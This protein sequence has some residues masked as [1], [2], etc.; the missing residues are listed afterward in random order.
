[1]KEFILSDESVNSNNMIV[2]TDGI[3][4][5]RFLK[6]PVM[7]YNHDRGKGV[8]GRWENIRKEGGKLYG[9]PVFDCHHE[10]GSKIQRQVEE[11]F[12]RAASIGIGYL[13]P[14]YDPLKNTNA[15]E[16]IL[17]CELLEAS[18]CD[19]PSNRNTLQLYYNDKPVDLGTYMK[20][21]FGQKCLTHKD[22]CKIVSALELPQNA[23][24]RQILKTINDL[25]NSTNF[26]AE[27]KLDMAIKSGWVSEAERS[28]LIKC[29]T[30][31]PEGLDIFLQSRQQAYDR[32]FE[33]KFQAVLHRNSGKFTRST[34]S[35]ADMS[36]L[37]N[38]AKSNLPAFEK[39]IDNLLNKRLVMDDIHPDGIG[40][41]AN[42]DRSRWTLEDYRK[43]DPIELRRNQA[44]Y[45]RLLQQKKYS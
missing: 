4:L 18:I 25:K 3:D 6:N 10:L 33:G 9:T 13:E 34:F 36:E 15:P 42:V 32:E 11:G 44:L 5:D 20:L 28:T 27:N 40:E 16:T 35:E 22:T 29:F 19:I 30:Q 31:A 1:M 14:E 23:T 12:I 45:H 21:S 2:R 38:F 41:T 39:M 26:S 7:F 24:V 43:N 37:K 8:V 17:A